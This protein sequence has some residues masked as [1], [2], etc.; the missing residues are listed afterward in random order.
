MDLGQPVPARFAPT[1]RTYEM[2]APHATRPAILLVMLFSL[3]CLC[4][5]IAFPYL[6]LAIVTLGRRARCISLSC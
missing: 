6:A 1:I 4:L 3:D 2:R 5:S